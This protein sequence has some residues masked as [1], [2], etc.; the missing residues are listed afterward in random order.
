MISI[1]DYK[2]N[3]DKCQK[4]TPTD[5]VE[6]MLDIA[7]YKN[8]LAGKKILEN[9]FGSGN[10]VIAIVK[11][12]IEDSIL[13]GISPEAIS[14]GLKSDIYGVELDKKLF[15]TCIHKLNLMVKAYGIPDVEWSLYN[16]DTL[17]WECPITFDFIIGNGRGVKG[18]TQKSAEFTQVS[19]IRSLFC[20]L[21][22][23]DG[24]QPKLNYEVYSVC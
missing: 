6:S 14:C 9:S 20:C 4:F 5:M 22:W 8:A 17:F 21:V 3:R 2:E 7:N 15:D 24:K 11:R 13:A 19:G 23:L 12:Y 18:Q 10:I 1:L 16:E